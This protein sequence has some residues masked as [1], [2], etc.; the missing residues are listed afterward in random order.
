M[1]CGILWIN[2]GG[3]NDSDIADIKVDD[4]VD[5]IDGDDNCI[6][7]NN[8]DNG[9]DTNNDSIN[10]DDDNKGMIIRVIIIKVTAIMRIFLIV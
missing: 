10:T 4:N 2:G 7:N 3:D 8:I 9:D 6:V 1:Q 5:D